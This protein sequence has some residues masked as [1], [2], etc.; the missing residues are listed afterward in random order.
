MTTNQILATIGAAVLGAT[1]AGVF[2]I[3]KEIYKEEQQRRKEWNEKSLEAFLLVNDSINEILTI[4]TNHFSSL[5]NQIN[6]ENGL[7]Q[8][9]SFTDKFHQVP[10]YLNIYAPNLV[11]KWDEVKEK[12]KENLE[13]IDE[14]KRKF[15][16]N[17]MQGNEI[18]IIDSHRLTMDAVVEEFRID[19]FDEARKTTYIR[20][21]F[22]ITESLLK[23]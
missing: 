13:L 9:S 10:F 21:N 17:S 1:F 5:A 7:L 18:K 11:P 14:T 6:P 8:A 20:K 16:N 3:L 22:L 23:V 15:K 2:G 4:Y 12:L 19:M